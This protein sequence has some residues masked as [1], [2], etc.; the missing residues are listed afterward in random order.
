[1][2]FKFLN[3]PD[4]IMTFGGCLAALLAMIALSRMILEESPKTVRGRTLMTADHMASDQMHGRVR[5]AL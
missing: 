3:T 1:M 2:A 4:R 5:E